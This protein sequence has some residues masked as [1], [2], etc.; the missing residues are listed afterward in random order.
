[1]TVLENVLIG[2]QCRSK[3]SLLKNM[4]HSKSRYDEENKRI[5]RAEEL[6]DFVGLI[7]QKDNLAKNLPYGKQRLLE[8]ARALGTSPEILLL[9]EPAAGMNPQETQELVQMIKKVR[10]EFKVTVLL[11]EHNMQLVMKLADTI[12]CLDYGSKIAEGLPC[13][14]AKDPHV[15]EAYLGTQHEKLESLSAQA[16]SDDV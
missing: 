5:E 11:I 6:L 4:V 9:D 8:I 2:L 12:T 16:C 15:I 14:V 7:D 10:D 3:Y 1:M 13:D